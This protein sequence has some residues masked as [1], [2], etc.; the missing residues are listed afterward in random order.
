MP[1]QIGER[2]HGFADPTNLLSDCHRRIEMFLG[3]LA[4]VAETID[5]PLTDETSRSLDAALRYFREAAPKHT[6]DEEKSLFPRLRQLRH[7]DIAAMLARL[8]PLESEHRRVAPLHSSID[9]LGVEYLKTG[10]LP[11]AGVDD[12]RSAVKELSDTYRQ[13][14]SIEDTVVFLLAAKLLSPSDKRAIAD[15]MAD[16]RNLTHTSTWLGETEISS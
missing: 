7:T 12:F 16:R 13:H 9:K 15:E 3:V 4:A 1:V 10:A 5:G 8:E 2:V 6:A 11:L 14:I